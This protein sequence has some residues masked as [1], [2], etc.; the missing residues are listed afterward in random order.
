[1]ATTPALLTPNLDK[2]RALE[3]I[4]IALWLLK[5]LSWCS[6]WHVLGML[7]AIPTII[8]SIRLCWL[9]RHSPAEL[10]HTAAVSLWICANITWMIGEFYYQD[11]TRPFAKIFFFAGAAILVVYY[12]HYALRGRPVDL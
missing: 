6:D 5:D 11:M 7:A 4:H 8:L 12:T 2:M 10:A 3:N 9:G 1:M